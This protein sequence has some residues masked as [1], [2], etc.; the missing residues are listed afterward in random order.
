MNFDPPTVQE[1]RNII[2]SLKNAAHGHDGIKSVLIKETIDYII[3]PL[4]H[5]LSLSLKTGIVP[6]NLKVAR[7]IPIFKTG[8][9]KEFSNYRP[10]S[11]LPCISKILERLVFSRLFNH[12]D[13]NNIL[14]KHQYGFRKRHSTEHALIQLVNYISSALD[15][16]KFALGVFLDLRH[17]IWSVTIF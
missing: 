4:T 6:Q 17:S 5:I 2:F 14:Y 13:A 7:V 12:L 3:K 1:V 16:K 8:D 11:I 9:S 10:I 15:N